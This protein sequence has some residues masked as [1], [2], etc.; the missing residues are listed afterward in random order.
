MRSI[1]L[2][3]LFLTQ[4]EL[5]TTKNGSENLGTVPTLQGF[6]D[7]LPTTKKVFAGYE[8]SFNPAT[9]FFTYKY[10]LQTTV[11]QFV[12]ILDTNKA[13]AI[14]IDD[15]IASRQSKAIVLTVE[16]VMFRPKNDY[17]IKVTPEVGTVTEALR[18][19]RNYNTHRYLR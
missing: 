14:I 13:L 15:T 7:M 1:S 11:L 18:Y 9:Q 12:E 17:R 16:K 4:C 2:L 8:T 19:D 10:S 6:Y 3:L 5:F